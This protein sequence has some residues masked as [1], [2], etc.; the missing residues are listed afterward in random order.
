V[1]LAA[2]CF[3]AMEVVVFSEVGFGLVFIF[4]VSWLIVGFG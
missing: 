3:M 1:G 4:I 2:R